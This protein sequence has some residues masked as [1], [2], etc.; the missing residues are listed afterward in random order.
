MTCYMVACE[1]TSPGEDYIELIAA[2]ERMGS[3]WRR[4]L[5]AVWVVASERSAA[6][7]RAELKPYL[8]NHDRLIV[9][10]LSAESAW[11]AMLPA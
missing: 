3:R 5:N 4:C 2:I 11:R 8:G 6:E 9:A 1:L 10:Q 7:L